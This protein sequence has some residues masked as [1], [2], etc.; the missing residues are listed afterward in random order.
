M[1]RTGTF[2][3]AALCVGMVSLSGHAIAEEAKDKAGNG[4]D[5]G[6]IA[7]AIFKPA[8]TA[9]V[10]TAQKKRSRYS[11]LINTYARKHGIPSSLAH[12]VVRVESNFN[13]DQAWHGA[14]DGLSRVEKGSV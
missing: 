11:R 1:N 9:K 6:A 2:L 4:I 8:E 12:A 5:L 7:S 13:A 10:S 3:C 14:H